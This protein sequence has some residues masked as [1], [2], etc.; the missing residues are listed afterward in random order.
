M[1]NNFL[2]SLI[3]GMVTSGRWLLDLVTKKKFNVDK[4]Q[5]EA[6]DPSVI[7]ESAEHEK[8]AD[9]AKLKWHS[10]IRNDKFRVTQKF[11]NP[12]P[13]YKITK[14]HPGTDYGTQ[15]EDNVPLYF[16]ADGEVIE[17]GFHNAFGNYF[18][19]YVPEADRTFIYFHLRDAAPAKGQYRIGEQCG[20]T[21][22]TGMSEGI[23]LHLECMRGRNISTDR[24]AF[25][26]SK[27]AI[28]TIAEDA[29]AF[30]RSRLLD[31]KRDIET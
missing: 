19:F 23:H 18:F 6:A 16:C 31:S 22:K 11:L 13:R 30:I 12:D 1:K 5:A 3:D 9:V 24:G 8:V 28:A 4:R 2:K 14:H 26:T 20:I 10:P 25:Y 7:S 17:S 29:D 21:G 15:G 27:E